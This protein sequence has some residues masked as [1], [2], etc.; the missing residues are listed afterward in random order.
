MISSIFYGAGDYDNSFLL[1]ENNKFGKYIPS[2]NFPD[3]SIAAQIDR[4]IKDGQR[5]MHSEYISGYE[6]KLE[7]E[8]KNRKKCIFNTLWKHLKFTICVLMVTYLI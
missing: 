1:E 6:D 2:N 4:Y 8:R 7:A 5:G 3:F